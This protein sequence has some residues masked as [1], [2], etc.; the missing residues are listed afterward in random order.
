MKKL[1]AMLI[2]II[3]L[4]IAIVFIIPNSCR[5]EDDFFDFYPE[6]KGWVKEEA[7]LDDLKSNK[8]SGVYKYEFTYDKYEQ[9]NNLNCVKRGGYLYDENIPYSRVKDTSSVLHKMTTYVEIN[10]NNAKFYAGEGHSSL[11]AGTLIYES[12]CK[13]NNIMAA[14]LFESWRLG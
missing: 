5:A 1:R 7:T 4:T 2:T 11:P 14:I 6:L 12:N 10:G 8:P 9:W 3:F 13:A